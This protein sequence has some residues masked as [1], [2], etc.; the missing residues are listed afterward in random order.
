MRKNIIIYIFIRLK[1][2]TNL[3]NFAEIVEKL[4]NAG[5]AIL[6]AIYVKKAEIALM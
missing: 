1:R 2:S 4:Q 5:K 6:N 3:S